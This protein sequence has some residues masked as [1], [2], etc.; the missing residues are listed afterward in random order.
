MKCNGQRECLDGSDEEECLHNNLTS[1]GCAENEFSCAMEPKKCIAVENVCD[2]IDNCGNNFDEPLECNLDLCKNHHC[3]HECKQERN[4]VKCIC[5]S[6]FKL[7]S[8]D[9]D[10]EDINECLEISSYCSGHQCINSVGSATC[11][12]AEGYRFNDETKRCKV[13]NGRNATIIYSNQNELR[14]TSLSVKSYLPTL[15]QNDQTSSNGIVRQNLNAIGMF[16]V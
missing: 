10:C 13:V 15:L 2:G 12:C 16:C 8:N 7:S 6:G 11:N 1:Y 4:I 14:N 9:I 3:A 5:R